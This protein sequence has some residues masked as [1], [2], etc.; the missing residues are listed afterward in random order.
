M[1]SSME[2]KDPSN[3]SGANGKEVVPEEKEEAPPEMLTSDYYKVKNMPER[4]NHPGMLHE[5]TSH[6]AYLY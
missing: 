1:A 6:T 3:E 4:F 5:L 2:S